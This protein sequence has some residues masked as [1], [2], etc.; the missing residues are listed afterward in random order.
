M[1]GFW[2]KVEAILPSVSRPG[3]YV[4]NELHAVRKEGA[5][6]AV[7]VV[8][9]FPDAY[10][11]GMSHVGFGI[12]YHV[13]N[14][15]DWIAAER[16]YAPWVDM[17]ARMREV[18]IPLF[19]LETKRRVRDFDVVGITL[20]YELQYTNVLNLLDLAGIPVR[21]GE[22]TEK[23]PLVVAGGPCAF[24]PEP[25]AE[26]LDAV[27]LGDGE[28]VVV[29]IAQV[30]R[31]GKEEGWGRR[32]TL[33]MLSG[34]AGVYVPG[35][36]RAESDAEGR[37]VGT[38]PT[39]EGAPPV[40]RARILDRLSPENYP[41]RPLVPLIEVTH[42]RFS[43]EIMRGCTRGCRFCNAGMIYRPVRERPVEELV[44]EAERVIASTGYDE[45]ALVSLSTSDCGRL[46]ELLTRLRASFPDRLVAISFPSLRPDSFTPAMADLAHGLRRSG[47]TFAPEAGTQRLR[48]VINKNSRE[49]DLLRAVEIGYERGW[50]RVKLY[51]MIGLPTETRE[52]LQGI[53]D[54]VGRVV[55][56]GRQYGRK[57]VH[58]SVSP[59]SPKPMTPFQWEVQDGLGVL[60]E[61]VGFLKQSMRWREVNLSWRDPRVSQVETAL[62][63]GDRRVG[64]A[65]YRAW[66][67][68]AR[69]DAWSDTFDY[70]GWVEAF[71]ERRLSLD[72]YTGRWRLEDSLPWDHLSKGVSKSYLLAER[73]RAFS[74][75]VT[76][77]CRSG[78]CGGCGLMAHPV[79]RG[80]MGSGDGGRVEENEQKKMRATVYGRRTRRVT[81]P[82]TKR[83]V[84]LGY[85]KGD[86][87]RFTSHLDTVRVFTRAL[88]RA[89]IP[90][91]MSQGYHAHP[92]MATGPP[93]P[94][95][96]TSRA[97]Y[98]DLEI[99]GS[100]RD[101]LAAV[102]NGQ[103]PAGF[104]VFASKVVWSKATSLTASINRAS[105]RI[106]WN[107]STGTEA[108][109]ERVGAFLAEDSYV[110]VRKKGEEE[111]EVDIRPYVLSLKEE[112]GGLD[113]VVRL[114][115]EGTVRV[116]EVVEAV[117]PGGEKGV[118]GV[119]VER[120]GL[121]I[122]QQGVLTTPLDV[123]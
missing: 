53:V 8:L 57:E 67:Q 94:L 113:L 80:L 6:V 83:R 75:T 116:D 88:R 42:D 64:G 123:E 101:D 45:V 115:A 104:E 19:S 52:D 65:I 1:E 110:V 10:E 13:L 38:V 100:V 91:A 18:G 14:R 81:S 26:F 50:Q 63:R 89:R 102:L 43:M 41:V 5:G 46:P 87:A 103:L 20:Q 85:R 96:V 47:L 111:K 86:E 90:V 17:E 48:D 3:R 60:E 109:G 25:L 2:E 97:E 108:L 77:D 98:L 62:G 4:G 36:Y 30:V 15:C 72:A 61:K 122:E 114:G 7:R 11:I 118:G 79:C 39:E 105:Y 117:L 99:V 31:R 73:E 92:R 78:G 32:Q 49:E 112:D 121:Y 59:F 84:R 40:V 29:E 35:F 44:D 56:L 27:V 28:E 120:T 16:V 9:A 37:F 34:L 95:G 66:E 93:L 119:Q 68:G 107:G 70:E 58:V 76:E 74:G 106:V 22:R 21:S 33:K 23:D 12:L 69:F 55:G 82:E 51:F 54:L 24:N 71:G